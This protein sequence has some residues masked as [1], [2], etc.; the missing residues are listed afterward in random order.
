MF[1]HELSEEQQLLRKS[2]REFAE[3]YPP[4]YWRRKD[5]AREYP[6][7]FIQD[8][9]RAGW[10]GVNI[11]SEYGGAGYGVT[12]ASIV[13][14]EVTAAG[15]GLSASGAAHASFFN[16]TVLARHG[17]KQLK[18]RYLP[19]VARGE[20]RFQSLAITEQGSGFDT[21][22]IRTLAVK[23]DGEYIV[24]GSKVFISRVKHS[25]LMLLVAR[26]TPYEESLKRTEGITLF[27]VDLR[28]AGDSIRIREIPN[29]TRRMVD[30]S[31]VFIDGLRVPEENVIGEV[32]K[33]FHHLLEVVNAER[34]EIA[35]ECIGLARLALRKAA[36]YSRQRVVFGRP[37]GQ[38]QAIAHPLAEA[39]MRIEAADLMRYRASWLYDNGMPC[40]PEA[41]MAKYL[42]AEAC[43]YSCDRAVQT[44]GGY[45]FS[46]EMDIERYWRESRLYLLAPISQEMVLNYISN[47][48]LRLPR[49]Y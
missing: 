42:A 12:E 2:I 10:M 11:P 46:T 19:A 27:L 22:S 29:N 7:E 33:G 34:I 5:E 13:L 47:N 49:S 20:L 39:Y 24:R 36:E 1:V 15:G 44:F 37:I 25:D 18:E 16:V 48:V 41:N 9:M 8:M 43:M 4:E 3:R 21:P 28:S 45:G 32:G 6:S 35:A 31:E 14:E 40:G 26:T 30:T 38:N 17:S 23:E